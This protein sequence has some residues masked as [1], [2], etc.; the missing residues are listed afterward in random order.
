MDDLDDSYKP[1][2]TRSRT[3]CL[4]CRKGKHKCDEE[5]PICKRCSNVGK[6]CVY[7]PPPTPKPPTRPAKRR[8]TAIQTEDQVEEIV[9]QND[10]GQLDNSLSSNGST[11]GETTLPFFLTPSDYLT[12]SFP[13]AQERD[14]MRHLLC[15]GNVVMYSVPVQNEPI[16]FLHLARCLQHS[17]GFSL[18]SDALLLSLI[19]IAAGHKSSL[20]AQQERRYLDQLPSFKWDV[21]SLNDNRHPEILNSFSASQSAQRSISDH[22]SMT[23]LSICK[24]TVAFR[25][26]SGT[27]GFTT[28]MSNL[29]LTSCLA[30]IIAQC[31]N[32]GTMWKQSYEI[33]CGLINLRG[34]PAKMLEE[35]RTLSNEEVSRIRLLLENFVVMDV[36]QCLASG[37]APSLMKEPFAMW[38]YDY[39]SENNDTVHNSYGVDR[40]LVEVANRV[41]MLVHESSI[42]GTVLDKAYLDTHNS[43]VQNV[44]QELYIW[45]TSFSQQ[46]I[47]NLRVVFGNRVM[48]NM[49]K[50][51]VYV[52]LLKKRHSDQEVQES[53][54]A[55][56]TAFKDG[57][58]LDHGVGLLLAAII[59]GS[60]LQD[61]VKRE[62]ARGMITRLRTT[63][64]YGYDVEEAVAMLDKIY[65]LRDE[66]M[67]DPSWRIVT[68]TSGFLLF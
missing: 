45:E 22:F 59:T 12:L 41:N 17:R 64:D 51:V 1:K 47:G 52:D 60:V 26:N 44:L 46:T 21:L 32:A 27:N 54:W 68:G 3:G 20:I 13:D 37:A 2:F 9:R 67:V 49:L 62:E 56:L 4:R 30:I 50:V 10:T 31:L 38:W 40:A 65:R 48:V 61:K 23:S 43:K 18:E 66:G 63:A 8:R 36:C 57:K 14:L 28:E 16:Q 11:G 29:L 15:F 6:E 55:A 7:P 39:I 35:A 33:A 53:A 25:S 58:E 5:K 42:L 34:G 19:S 24:T